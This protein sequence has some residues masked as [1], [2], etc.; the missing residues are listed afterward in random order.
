MCNITWAYDISRA[1]PFITAGR[2]PAA[3]RGL[4][5]SEKNE[6]INLVGAF[7]CQRIRQTPLMAAVCPHLEK[8][9]SQFQSFGPGSGN[10]PR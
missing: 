3:G 7:T 5:V 6:S 2:L 9:M 4:S 1:P 8:L 10:G